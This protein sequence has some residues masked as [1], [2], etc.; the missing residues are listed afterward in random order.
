ML[1]RSPSMR[2]ITQTVNAS[3]TIYPEVEVKVSSDVS[4]EI[5]ELFVQEGDSVRAGQLLAKI[6]PEIYQSYVERSDAAY[7]SALASIESAKAGLD[8]ANASF[9]KAKADFDRQQKLYNEHII[10]LQ[11]WVTA[12]ANYKN[13]KAQVAQANE[14]V[15]SARFNANSAKANVKESQGNLSKTTI[16][17][18][19]SGIVSKLNVE[20]GE[21]ENKKLK[22]SGR[23]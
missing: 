14:N 4:G 22:R 8:Q 18:P 6:K 9:D 10:S 17:A 2:D 3:G 15:Q 20:K 7:Q 23:Q 5:T 19:M 21:R 11:D 1:F 13:A 16:L 12:Q